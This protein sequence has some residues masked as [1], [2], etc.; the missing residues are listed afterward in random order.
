VFSISG[1]L[2]I[3]A[4]AG[5]DGLFRSSDGGMSWQRILGSPDALRVN[6]VART[7]ISSLLLAGT[8]SGFSRSGDIGTT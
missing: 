8:E 3:V 5:V 6:T 7:T 1:N 2:V 4:A